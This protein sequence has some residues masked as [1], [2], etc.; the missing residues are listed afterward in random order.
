M[1]IRAFFLFLAGALA[2]LPGYGQVTPHPLAQNRDS[3]RAHRI[4]V[5]TFRLD[6]TNRKSAEYTFDRR[7]RPVRVIQYV[8]TGNLVQQYTHRGRRATLRQ[9]YIAGEST[10]RATYYL[11]Y[12]GRGRLVEL[13]TFNGS[14]EEVVTRY[15]YG[16]NGLPVSHYSR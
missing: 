11:R 3:I 15:Q 8:L 14:G 16:T 7:G 5:I 12:D 13:S 9:T 6:S 2:A 4:A 10:Q 1:L